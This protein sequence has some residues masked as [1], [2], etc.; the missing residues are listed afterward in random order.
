MGVRDFSSRL[1]ARLSALFLL[2]AALLCVVSCAT[3]CDLLGVEAPP[4]AYGDASLLLGRLEGYQERAGLR[5]EL[6][7]EGSRTI[8]G[9]VVSFDLYDAAGDPVPAFGRNH[10][11]DS[12]DC[13]IAAGEEKRF[14]ANLDRLFFYKP[15][16]G[17]IAARL[18]I[19]SA[20]FSDGGVWRDGAEL[21]LRPG[22]VAAEVL[23]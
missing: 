20:V 12:F 15:D 1:P 11:S 17:I 5:F 6:R 16:P 7:N 9:L 4:F 13:T 21:F 2:S 22:V 3:A 18:R 10:A 8:V 14:L 19:E 23:P